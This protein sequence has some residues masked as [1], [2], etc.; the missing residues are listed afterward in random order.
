VVSIVKILFLAAEATP[1]VKVGGL[2]DVAGALPRALTELGVDVRLCLPFYPLIREAGYDVRHVLDLDIPHQTGAEPVSLHQLDW[3]GMP[4]YLVDAEAVRSDASIY[5][6][7]LQGG[8]KFTL[9]S[10]T[11]LKACQALDWKPD[12]VH[13]NDWHTAMCVVWLTHHRADN[14]FW[15]DVIGIFSIHNLAYMG[16][17][18]ERVLDDYGLPASNDPL[19]PDWARHTPLPMALSQA[20]WLSTVSPTYAQE[21]QTTEFGY[22]LESLL[23][24][25]RNRLVGILNGIDPQI[26]DP[27]NDDALPMGFSVD[28]IEPRVRVKEALQE[29]L[30]FVDDDAIPLIAMVTRL[31]RQKGIDLAFEALESSQDEDWQFVLLGT[32]SDELKHRAKVFADDFEKRVRVI[33][34][35]DSSL[36]RRIYAGADMLL[37][38]SRY[39]PCG[40][41]QLIAMRYGCVPIVR[42]TGGLKDTVIPYD[43]KRGTGFLFKNADA[44][45]L[46]ASISKAISVYHSSNDWKALQLRCMTQNHSWQNAANQY[47]RLY[48]QMLA[49]GQYE[50]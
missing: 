32:G 1:F 25:R 44:Q 4:V 43:H 6:D 3:Q 50:A 45:S 2:A 12:V 40:L 35:F 47:L 26:W 15:Q 39:E 34:R 8:K 48:E 22:G 41:A 21:I 14:P 11:A 18:I 17:G 42:E 20:D 28:R 13:A 10:L 30:D 7:T 49:K 46:A 23:Q 29:E 38:P 24:A 9:T 16:A 36:A 31:D 33:L 27:A 37:V 5:G 19:L